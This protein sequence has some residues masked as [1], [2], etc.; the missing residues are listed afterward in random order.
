MCNND[1]Q[2]NN[3]DVKNEKNCQKTKK[4]GMEEML[5]KEKELIVLNNSKKDKQKKLSALEQALKEFKDS[6]GYDFLDMINNRKIKQKHLLKQH[7]VPDYDDDD[8]L[9]IFQDIQDVEKE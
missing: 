3:A 9:N 7:Q 5:T 8:F 6:N 1:K 2:N 4:K